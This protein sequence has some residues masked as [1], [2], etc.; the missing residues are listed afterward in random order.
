M[1]EDVLNTKAKRKIAMFFS[2]EKGHFQVS[3]MSRRLG[4][5]KSRA[6]E[7]LKE[8]EKSGLLK[9]RVIGRSVIY[10]RSAAKSAEF[11]FRALAQDER[12]IEEIEKRLKQEIKTLKPVSVARFG[13]SLKGLKSGSDV[14]IFVVFEEKIREDELH[15]ISA[16]LS[17]EFGVH[18]SI[19]PMNVKELRRKAKK[20]E[21]FSVKLIAT[22]KLL[23]GKNLEDLIWREKQ[24][25]TKR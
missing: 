3:D 10:G 11:I 2:K 16:K 23:Y 13:S 14:D 21:E 7:C 17:E 9:G 25:K 1:L 4:I 8:L 20:G 18:I 5:S 12:L 15:N 22:H 19:L 24:E 6:S